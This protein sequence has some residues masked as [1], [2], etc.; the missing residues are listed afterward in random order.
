M[1]S[2]RDGG[3]VK[4]GEKQKYWAIPAPENYPHKIMRF[5]VLEHRYVM[6]QHL[7]R[8]L[9]SDEIVHHINENTHDN[10]IEN[11]AVMKRGDH[12]KLHLIKNYKCKYCDKK[13]SAKGLCMTHYNRIIGNKKRVKASY[14][15][16]KAHRNKLSNALLKYYAK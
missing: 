8:M 15:F 1:V 7:G 6:E 5:Y 12:A 11:L 3:R 13:R 2:K 10:R 16:S 14:K 4:A 9:S